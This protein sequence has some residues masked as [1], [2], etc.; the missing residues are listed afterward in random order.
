MR[1]NGLWLLMISLTGGELLAGAEPVVYERFESGFAGTVR[2][3]VAHSEDVV[4]YGGLT[5]ANRSAAEFSG[6]TAACLDYGRDRQVPQEDFTVEAFVYVSHRGGY[7]AIAGDWNEEGDNRS[8]AF[9]LTPRGGLRFDVSPDGKFYG[10]NKL[11]TG[12]RFLLPSQWYHVAAVSSGRTS[13][14]F[15][16]GRQVAASERAV[17][18]LNSS[19]QANLKVGNIDL[20]ATGGPRPWRG[21]LDEVRITPC[22][23]EP[24]EFVRTRQ[25][26]PEV[27]GGIPVEYALPFTAESPEAARAWQHLARSRLF[28]LVERQEPRRSTQELPLD[29][30][31]G[32]PED[33]DSYRLYPAS[34]QGNDGRRVECWFTVPQ[35]AGPFPA[36]LALHGHGG[37]RDAVFDSA[38]VYQG[39]ADH[40]ARGG[41][42]VLAP[43][44]PHREYCATMLWDL[45]R[46][47]DILSTREEVDARRLGVAGLSMGGEWTMWSAA[48]D[49]RLRVAVVSGWMCTTEG[50]FSVPNCD[51]WEL[52]G[53][54]ELMDVCEVHLLIA[55][56]PLLFE[57]AQRDG[58]FPIQYT[59]Q[60]YERVRAGYRLFG[61]EDQ[62]QQDTWPAGHE[63]HGAVAYPFVDRVL[64][65]HA[66]Q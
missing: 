47:V 37:S 28:E 62:V 11:E 13:R 60:G 63:W 51:C 34:F 5:E 61:A 9:V 54:V 10:G 31:L 32:E 48:C 15:I 33:R 36:L 16:N 23:L 18:G 30:Q 39:F 29:F 65:G 56:R 26:M 42:V 1:R 19:D 66:A 2:G 50:V 43:S 46:L 25:P 8:W 24:A 59:R 58:C 4:G 53:F 52:P 22:A 12:P 41:Y 17:P 57:S 27:Q 20:F 35:G 55:P 21:K 14:I 49:E 7:A 38:T 6:S 44:F 45:I 40:F 3:D 64:G